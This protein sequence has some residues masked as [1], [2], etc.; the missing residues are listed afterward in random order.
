MR[1]LQDKIVVIT[2]AGSGFGRALALEVVRH[3]GVPVILDVSEKGLA[4]TGELIA[5]AGGRSRAHVLDVRDA[6]GWQKVADAV[7]AEFG[8]VDVLIN[9]AG[10]FSRAESFL[11][12]TEEHGRFIF[13]VNVWGPFHGTRVFAPY[14]AQ[15]P[16]AAI[17]NVASSLAIITTPMHSMYCASKAAV[18]S[19]S[20]VLRQELADSNVTVTVVFP[21]PSK[22]NL[23]RNVQ[24]NDDAKRE[25]DAKNFDKFAFT[26][27]E[28]VARKIIAG[29]RAKKAFV[30]PSP[31]VRL[32]QFMQRLAPSAGINL[33]GKMYRRISDPKLF[34]RLRQLK[35]TSA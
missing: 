5:K 35:S 17:V 31:D 16:E 15:R 23:G 34:S 2:G 7:I 21:G 13:D 33:M 14:L 10:V 18:A 12:I 27:A 11:E 24:T 9:N 30:M 1:N 26:P 8:H 3:K 32:M 6:G 28:V 22:T 20:S 25:E 19:F 29:I 4:E